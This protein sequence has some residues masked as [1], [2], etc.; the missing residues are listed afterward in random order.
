[1]TRAKLLRELRGAVKSVG[2]G[3]RIR[4]S[5]EYANEIILH[6]SQGAKSD[7]VLRQM[8]RALSPESSRKVRK[9]D[10]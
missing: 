8:R 10:R 9:N 6:L 4:I 1:M 7:A 5:V 3:G 2:K